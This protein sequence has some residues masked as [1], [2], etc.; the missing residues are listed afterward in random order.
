MRIKILR[1]IAENGGKYELKRMKI[2][3]MARTL[4]TD[5]KNVRRYLNNLEK[6]KYIARE[7]D[8]IYWKIRLTKK[9][10]DMLDK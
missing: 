1:Y 7:K 9:S 3:E 6:E 2:R 4:R 5:E 10:R 8:F